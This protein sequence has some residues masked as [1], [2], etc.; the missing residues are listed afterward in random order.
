MFSAS[1]FS[2]WLSKFL[3]A[4]EMRSGWRS[5]YTSL[6]RNARVQ[7]APAAAKWDSTWREGRGEEVEGEEREGP[8]LCLSGLSMV[9]VLL[10]HTNWISHSRPMARV[11]DGGI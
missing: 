3:W 2:R 5:G 6:V 1:S 10:Y 7:G 4:P 9:D 11:E 8:H